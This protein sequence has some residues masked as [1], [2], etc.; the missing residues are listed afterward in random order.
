MAATGS[1]SRSMRF[2]A[3]LF[4]PRIATQAAANSTA[5][6]NAGSIFRNLS[7]ENACTGCTSR[8]STAGITCT[9]H[10]CR[11]VFGAR[12]EWSRPGGFHSGRPNRCDTR[13]MH[14]FLFIHVA[15]SLD[16]EDKIPCV[17][18]YAC[19][20]GSASACNPALFGAAGSTWLRINSRSA[21]DLGASGPDA[22]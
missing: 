11:Q 20:G 5:M 14:S 1:A 17:V 4:G 18:C 15:S 16:F 2:C 9:N 13:H 19:S 7:L 6:S 3:A 8:F 10:W 22:S 21:A 12:A